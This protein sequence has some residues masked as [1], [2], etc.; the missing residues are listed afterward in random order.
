MSRAR[1]LASAGLAATMVALAPSIAAAYVQVQP[2]RYGAQ[3]QATEDAITLDERIEVR[4]TIDDPYLVCDGTTVQIFENPGGAEAAIYL[5]TDE[6]TDQLTIDG[7]PQALPAPISSGVRLWKEPTKIPAHGAIEVR[8]HV[9]AFVLRGDSAS[10]DLL[11]W[12]VNARHPTL[13]GF[14]GEGTGISLYVKGADPDRLPTIKARSQ[15]LRVPAEWRCDHDP[16]LLKDEVDHGVRVLTRLPGDAAGELSTTATLRRGAR[17]FVDGGPIFAAGF[18]FEHV[19]GDWSWAGRVRF[20]WEFGLG[21]WFLLGLTGQTIGTHRADGAVEVIFATPS[22]PLIAAIPSIS[23]G[24]GLPVTIERSPDVGLRMQAGATWRLGG[25][26][27]GVHA[28]ADR[29]F[30]AHRWSVAPMIQLGI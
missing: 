17:A 5:E 20:G 19:P 29:Y 28:L 21:S 15:V 3:T 27:L 2:V 6:H 1:H 12:G 14:P 26:S 4:C 11:R 13:G 24:L 9:E 10:G 16:K 25:V 8:T 30:A 23:L 7:K 22:V 18:G